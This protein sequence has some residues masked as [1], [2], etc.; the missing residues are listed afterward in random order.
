MRRHASAIAVADAVIW[1]STFLLAAVLAYV[2]G[3]AS[4]HRLPSST[5][6]LLLGVAGPLA[7]ACAVIVPAPLTRPVCAGIA[8]AAL[9][10]ALTR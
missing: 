2:A 5:S 8:A 6:G 10:L 3:A 1:C 9:L 4:F 7:A